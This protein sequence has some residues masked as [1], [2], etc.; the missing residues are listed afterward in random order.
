LRLK[1]GFKVLVGGGVNPHLLR[2]F[3][4]L[5]TS[6]T[7]RATSDGNFDDWLEPGGGARSGRRGIVVV[8]RFG[9]IVGDIECLGERAFPAFLGRRSGLLLDPDSGLLL[10]WYWA[11]TRTF[12][13]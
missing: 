4:S 5:L 8:L 7:G 10:D 6:R 1:D 9:V 3:G 2:R 12:S 11:R 13:G